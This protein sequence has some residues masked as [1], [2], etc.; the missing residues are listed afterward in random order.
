MND[1]IFLRQQA[2]NFH[3]QGKTQTEIAVILGK[4]RQWVHKWVKRYKSLGSDSWFK[5]KATIPKVITNKTPQR[6]ENLIL[7]IRKNLGNTQYSQKGAL[8]ILYELKRLGV[9]PPSISTI[10]RILKRNNLI[11]KSSFKKSKKKII[12][13]ILTLFNKWI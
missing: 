9:E 11:E 12:P 3:L 10:N 7:E 5:S 4:S 1:E 8:N 2:I 6:I 13:I